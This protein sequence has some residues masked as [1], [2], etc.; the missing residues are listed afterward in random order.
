MK[1]MLL[2]IFL[3]LPLLAVGRAPPWDPTERDVAYGEHER[4]RLDFWK[5]DFDE[6]TPVLIYIH[7]GGFV[8]GDKSKAARG[9]GRK[10]IMDS[11]QKGVSCVSIN[12][13]FRPSSRTA[14]KDL[15][16]WDEIFIHIARAIQ[17]VRHKAEDWNIDPKR[18]GVYGNS[19]GAGSSL[20]LAFHDDLADP[21]NE[22]PV[23][24]ESSKP[25]VAAAGNPQATYDLLRWAELLAMDEAVTKRAIQKD[26]RRELAISLIMKEED[27]E[28]EEGVRRRRELDFLEMIDKDDPP[29]HL[30]CTRP[31]VIPGDIIHHPRHVKVLQKRCEREGV[32]C[33]V[34]LKETPEKDRIERLDF[35]LEKLLAEN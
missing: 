24:R 9:K 21:D 31:D 10:E 5:A 19:A 23:L 11:L 3:I 27:L 28:K 2:P 13:P 14:A 1:R 35:L 17:F 22:D 6:P 15:V 8:G 12:Y 20:W 33:K 16:A 7:G 34:L 25:I 29:V 32:E 18:L 26:P 30:A 4:N